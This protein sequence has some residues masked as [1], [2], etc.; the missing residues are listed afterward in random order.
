MAVKLN[1]AELAGIRA[2]WREE[3]SEVRTVQKAATI[4]SSGPRNAPESFR[5]RMPSS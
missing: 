2:I 4:G 5:R 1:A 3:R